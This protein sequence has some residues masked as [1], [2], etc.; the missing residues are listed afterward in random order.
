[1]I[2]E[3]SN[4]AE[5]GRRKSKARA[6]QPMPDGADDNRQEEQIKQSMPVRAFGSSDQPKRDSHNG[7][8]KSDF[9]NPRHWQMERLVMPPADEPQQER[10]HNGNTED[11]AHDEGGRSQDHVGETKRASCQQNSP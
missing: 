10:G 1:M 2:V 5:L 11:I 8:K 9:R 7:S 6:I 3:Q 4:Q